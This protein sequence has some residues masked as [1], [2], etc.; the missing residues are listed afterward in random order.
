VRQAE[1]LE[2]ALLLVME[3]PAPMER[4]AYILREAFEYAYADIAEM[5]HI[6]VANARKITSRAR[7][8]L[9]AER[10]QATTGG[11]ARSSWRK[12]CGRGERSR[13]RSPSCPTTVRVRRRSLPRPRPRGDAPPV[14]T[15]PGDAV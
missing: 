8:R 15:P 11:C 12:T 14:D 7:K 3:K 1:E 4:A 2:L 6:G 9:A 13:P 10:P 5:L